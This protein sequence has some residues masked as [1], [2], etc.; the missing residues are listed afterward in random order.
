M[1]KCLTLAWKAGSSDSVM[2]ALLSQ[3]NVVADVGGRPILENSVRSHIA[4]FDASNAVVYSASHED[5]ATV[6]CH[7]DCQDTGPEPRVNRK[8]PTL[9]LVSGQ[10]AQSE[11]V[12]PVILISLFPP[13]TSSRSLDPF[14]YRTTR[15][16][17]FQ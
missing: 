16:A 7:L 12:K 14:K 11:S 8:P 2:A 10:L 15:I 17:A 5:V 1:S 13:S 9:R 3:S 4:S 6:R